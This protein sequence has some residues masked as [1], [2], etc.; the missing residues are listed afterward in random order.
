VGIK[1]CGYCGTMLVSVC[2]LTCHIR[3]QCAAGAFWFSVCFLWCMWVSRL[4]LHVIFVVSALPAL[5]GSV[6]VFYGGDYAV[7]SIVL[8]RVYR[9]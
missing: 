2:L 4:I 6:Y 9:P 7:C 8:Y 5:F 3:G 1:L